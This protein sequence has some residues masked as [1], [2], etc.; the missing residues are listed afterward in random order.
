MGP[1]IFSVFKK[2]YVEVV[3]A[4]KIAEKRSKNENTKQLVNFVPSIAQPLV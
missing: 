1:S 2:S 3:V 4:I